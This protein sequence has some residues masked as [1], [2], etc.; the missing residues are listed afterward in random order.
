MEG[1]QRNDLL[2]IRMGCDE[3]R[4]KPRMGNTLSVAPVDDVST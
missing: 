2:V 4:G 1:K 3:G